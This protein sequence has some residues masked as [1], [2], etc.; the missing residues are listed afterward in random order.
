MEEEVLL[1]EEQDRD[2]ECG[3]VSCS[4]VVTTELESR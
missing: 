1:G 4:D 2:G 3:G